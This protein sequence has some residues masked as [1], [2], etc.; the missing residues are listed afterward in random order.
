V[1]ARDNLVTHPWAGGLYRRRP[2]IARRDGP[3]PLQPA[4]V[5]D[6]RDRG[7]ASMADVLRDNLEAEGY[8]VTVAPDGR[9]GEAPGRAARSTWWCS[10]SCCR[11]STASPCARRGA[12]RAT[13][14]GPVPVGAGRA[15]GPGP[16]AARRRRRLPA[17]AVPPARVPAA[18][19]GAAAAPRLGRRARAAALRRPH[20][21]PARVDRDAGRRPPGE[22]GR[23]RARHP[24][25]ARRP[26]RRGG[27]PRRHPRRGLGRR[28]VPL[29]AHDRQRGAAAAAPVRARPVAPVH[30]HT[31]WGVGYRFTVQPED[32]PDDEEER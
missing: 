29:L 27:A 22:P 20:R 18:G 30:L 28:R 9:A 19:R 11:A 16:R 23:A 8:R 21:R 2:V 4:D 1:G 3:D 17:Q 14:A 15:R 10:T 25:P 6:R 5:T 24:A 31:V 13:D 26:R 32:G 12:P 7:R